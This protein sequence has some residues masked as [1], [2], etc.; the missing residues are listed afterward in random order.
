MSEGQRNPLDGKKS[1]NYPLWA[2]PAFAWLAIGLIA[3]LLSVGGRWS[4]PLAAWIA[5]IFLLRFSRMSRLSVAIPVL[6]ALSFLQMIWMGFEYAVDLTNNATSFFLAFFLGLFFAIPYV[7]DRLLAERLNDIGRLLFFPTAWAGLEFAVGSILPAGTSVGMR[8]FTQSENL[9]LVQVTSLMGPYIIG[10]L[11]GLCATTVN[12]IWQQPSRR[13]LVRWGGAYAALLL[14]VVAGGEVRLSFGATP[15]TA[16]MVKVAGIT[17]PQPLREQARKLVTMAN[18]PPTEELKAAIATEEMKALYAEVAQSMLKE[19]RMAARS[20]AQIVVWS[21][22]A[23]PILEAEKPALLQQVATLASEENVYVLASIGVPFETNENFLFGPDGAELWHYH[24]NYPVPGLEP[25]ASVDNVPPLVET[26][27][28]RVTS[29]ICFDGDFPALTRVPAD[30]LLLP[31]WDWPAMGFTHTMKMARLRAIENGYSLIRVDQ[32]GV[33]AAFDPYGRVLAMQ[34]TLSGRTSM[35]IVDMPTVRVPTLYSL[36]GDLF[37][38]LC[39][40]SAALLCGIGILRPVTGG[41]A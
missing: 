9:A 16:P 33:S 23:A 34:D 17:S 2:N 11:I 31:A 37:A 35:M 28:G 36:I 13:S 10:F 27:Y 18:F 5:P 40:A 6:V 4:I 19:T 24:K 12:H 3:L 41:S 20:G 38:W 30:I 7:L 25:V 8:A 29:V 21:E 1:G 26:P 32:D 15:I 14:L 22:T 39:L